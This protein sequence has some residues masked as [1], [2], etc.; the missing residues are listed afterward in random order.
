MKKSLLAVAVIG[1]FASAAQAQSSVTVYG[2]MDGGYSSSNLKESTAAGVRTNTNTAGYTGGESAT[3]RVG[4]RGVEDMG[5]GLSA[6]FN[7]EYAIASGTGTTGVTTAT[8]G[9]T[10]GSDSNSVRTSIVGISSKELGSLAVGRQ[11]TGMHAILAGDVWGGNNMAGDITY[12]GTTS[13]AAGAGATATG[14][15]NSVTTRSSNMVTYISPTIMGASLR[16]DQGN[17]EST[18]LN[19]PGIQFAMTGG[20]LTYAYGPFSAKVG[21]VKAK[22]NEALLATNAYL[23]TQTTVNGGN[24]MYKKDAITVQYTMGQNKTE[25]LAATG[26]TLSS[27]VRAQKLSASYQVGRFMPF[28]QY[29][30]GASEG[31]RTAANT[32]TE[33][34]AYQLGSEYAFSKRTNLYAAYGV[35]ERS[36]KSNSAAKTEYT[37]FAIGVRHTF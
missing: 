13:T 27:G 29:G 1:A 6:T 34:K 31:V 25:A 8:A 5:G 22:S 21:Q 20:Y 28:V 7:L 15:V 33:D 19:Q 32:I 2:L 17:T 11:L 10:Q 35:S 16:L 24:V 36:L 23:A 9:A 26:T 37:D 12:F 14:R 4:F 3:S 18:A 30:I